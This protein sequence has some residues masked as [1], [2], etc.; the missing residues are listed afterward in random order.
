VKNKQ[1]YDLAVTQVMHYY[2]LK[3]NKITEADFIMKDGPI[4][5]A[6][7]YASQYKHCVH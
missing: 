5:Q 3:V 2:E 4:N 1:H 6:S 7:K